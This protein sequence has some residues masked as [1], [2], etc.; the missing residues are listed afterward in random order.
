MRPSRYTAE[1]L[2]PGPL[3]LRGEWPG[4]RPLPPQ[5]TRGRE[6]R[7]VRALGCL[8]DPETGSHTRGRSDEDRSQWWDHDRDTRQHTTASG[9][10]CTLPLGSVSVGTHSSPRTVLE[11]A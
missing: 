5:T 7:H 3:G 11:G 9:S 6:R 1:K 10:V 4:V 2:V 8:L